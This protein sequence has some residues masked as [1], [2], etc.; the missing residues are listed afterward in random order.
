MQQLA[1][2]ISILTFLFQLEMQNDELDLLCKPTGQIVKIIDQKISPRS[3]QEW[4]TRYSLQIQMD[5]FS[6]HPVLF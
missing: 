5:L 3:I 4:A 2:L 6:A 1:L